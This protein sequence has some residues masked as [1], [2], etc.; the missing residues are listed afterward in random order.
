[1]IPLSPIHTHPHTTRNNRAHGTHSTNHTK[2]LSSPQTKHISQSQHQNS[3]QNM[4]TQKTTTQHTYTVRQYTQ[5]S[6][7]FI[8]HHNKKTQLNIHTLPPHSC[9]AQRHHSLYHRP[10]KNIPISQNTQG[11]NKPAHSRTTH[12]HSTQY[13]H[14]MLISTQSQPHNT[15][16]TTQTQV[17][18]TYTTQSTPQS[19]YPYCTHYHKSYNSITGPRH[20]YITQHTTKACPTRK[21]TTHTTFITTHHTT[22]HTILMH[23]THHIKAEEQQHTTQTTNTAPVPTHGT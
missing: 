2:C 10:L 3:P 14:L 7:T 5:P 22:P 21:T 6:H 12:T 18:N 13:K 23:R 19:Q 1:M 15:Y 8:P 4:K 17:H 20:R 16:P 9:T 11:S